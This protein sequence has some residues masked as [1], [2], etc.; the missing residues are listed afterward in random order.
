MEYR[1]TYDKVQAKLE[2]IKHEKERDKK[3]GK[4]I[5][6]L[7]TPFSRIYTLFIIIYTQDRIR[8][9]TVFGKDKDKKESTRKEIKDRVL[10]D[11]VDSGAADLVELLANQLVKDEKKKLRPGIRHKKKGKNDK[12]KTSELLLLP[13]LPLVTASPLLQYGEHLGDQKILMH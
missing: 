13:W 10:G 3:R 4:L 11:V 9:I 12:K 7:D 6:S 1:T 2:R 8:N 5:V